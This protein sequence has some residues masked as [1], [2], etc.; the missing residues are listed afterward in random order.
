MF[1]GRETI[2][3]IQKFPVCIPPF[4]FTQLFAVKEDKISHLATAESYRHG[5]KLE[6]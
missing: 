2:V 5:N 6:T 3:V 4:W 1:D